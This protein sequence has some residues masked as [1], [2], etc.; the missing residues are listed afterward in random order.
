MFDDAIN[1]CIAGMIRSGKTSLARK[2]IW[3]YW[4]TKSQRAIVLDPKGEWWPECCTVFR[5]AV[6]DVEGNKDVCRKFW[7]TAWANTG[8]VIVADE[9]AVTIARERDLMPAFTMM[10][11]Q[12]HRF[13]FICHSGS[14]LLPG[15]RG[16]IDHLFLFLQS[17][18]GMDVWRDQFADERL[19]EAVRLNQFEC[20]LARRFKPAEKMLL[21]P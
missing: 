15:M 16:Q 8:C 17:P 18:E 12:N 5:L 1:I 3:H 7:E 21:T 10:N 6:N 11:R 2:L 9:A 13:V 19:R 4:K 20:L 14:D